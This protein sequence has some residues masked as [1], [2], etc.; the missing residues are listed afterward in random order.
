MAVER[1]LCCSI[2]NCIVRFFTGVV[3][4][5]T[6]SNGKI[7]RL[8]LYKF[9]TERIKAFIGELLGSY[10]PRKSHMQSANKIYAYRGPYVHIIYGDQGL[11]SLHVYTVVL[12]WMHF[13][14]VSFRV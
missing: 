14:A 9:T 2:A 11:I 5:E 8:P 6:Q 7:R 13:G 1:N 12:D 4:A 10:S 3:I